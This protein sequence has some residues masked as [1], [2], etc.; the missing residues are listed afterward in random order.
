MSQHDVHAET[1]H[2]ADDTLRYRKRFAIGRRVGPGHGNFLAFQI[3]DTAK[4]IDD[5]GSICHALRRMIDITLEVDQ[6]R[7]LFE[8]A[9]F[10]PLGN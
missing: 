4:G 6:R 7:F 3:L 1:G 8:D 2:E 10:I 5:V 9:V